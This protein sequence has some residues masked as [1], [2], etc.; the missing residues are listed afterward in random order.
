MDESTDALSG[1][2]G[3]GGGGGGN[4]FPKIRCLKEKNLFPWGTKS[5]LLDSSIFQKGLLVQKSKQ[6]V[7]NVVSHDSKRQKK[8]ILVFSLP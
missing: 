6:E 8:I 5:C 3:G 7:T 2:S 4:Y 1:S